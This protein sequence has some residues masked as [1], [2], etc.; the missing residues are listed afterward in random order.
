[1][2]LSPSDTVNFLC[3]GSNMSSVDTGVTSSSS[4]G[5]QDVNSTALHSAGHL[6]SYVS[7]H[8]ERKSIADLLLVGHCG[9]SN[10]EQHYLASQLYYQVICH[11]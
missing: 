8:L 4:A 1:M 6:M 2:R 5:L 3:S 7:H 9:V 10:K 11:A